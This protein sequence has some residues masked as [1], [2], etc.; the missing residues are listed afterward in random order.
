MMYPILITICTVIYLLHYI[1]YCTLCTIN[2]FLI[3][4]DRCNI[5]CTTFYYS[6]RFSDENSV[7]SEILLY[8]NLH[9]HN[10]F[11]TVINID[12]IVFC[13]TTSMQYNTIIYI[14]III[15]FILLRVY[16]TILFMLLHTK[17]YVTASTF[18]FN[19]Y[20]LFTNYVQSIR[21]CIAQFDR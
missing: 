13:L 2:R 14:D 16:S 21:E 19:C 8:C 7:N 6:I 3:S 9:W 10:C 1:G 12:T 4:F 20:L 15:V 5:S 18:I 17:L 11:C